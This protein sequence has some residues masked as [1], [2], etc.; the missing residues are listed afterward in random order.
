MATRHISRIIVL[1]SLYEWSF[2]NYPKEKWKEIFERNLNEF[3]HDIEN[4]DFAYK[5][6]EGIVNNLE[7]LDNMIKKCSKNWPFEHIPLMEK[8]IL[9]MAIY[10]IYFEDKNEVPIKVAINEAIE[11]AKTFI[12]EASAKF[13]NGVLGTVYEEFLKEKNAQEII[14]NQ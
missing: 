4:K 3:G 9:R 5:L 12:T 10:E 6:I 1:Q 2:W 7:F 13:I 14:K 8:N 11:L